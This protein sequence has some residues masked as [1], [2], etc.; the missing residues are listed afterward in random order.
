[1]SQAKTTHRLHVPVL[2]AFEKGEELLDAFPELDSFEEFKLFR[3]K[4]L[5]RFIVYCFLA[6]DPGSAFV[7]KIRDLTKRK[8]ESAKE[9]GLLK[10]N[11][12]IRDRV[13]PA[14]ALKDKEF[15]AMVTRFFRSM[16]HVD[17]FEEWVSGRELLAQIYENVRNPVDKDDAKSE[18]I[19]KLKIEN[20]EKAPNIRKRLK[21]L[22]DMLFAGDKSFRESAVEAAAKVNMGAVERFLSQ[23]KD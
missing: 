11:N 18:A 9:A 22:E 16:V 17:E 20:F 2:E 23:N 19:Y 3:G 8:G 5:N 4:D 7:Q 15:Q 10:I 1:M 13:E 14:M 12:A 6:Y 21:D